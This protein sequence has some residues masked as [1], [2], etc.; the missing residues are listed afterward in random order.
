MPKTGGFRYKASKKIKNF[1][2]FSYFSGFLEFPEKL[3]VFTKKESAKNLQKKAKKQ[4]F[5]VFFMF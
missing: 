4:S 2:K 5:P 3:T 1:E